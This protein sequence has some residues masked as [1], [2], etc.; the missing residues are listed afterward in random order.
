MTR[1]SQSALPDGR[2]SALSADPHASRSHRR[3]WRLTHAN[4]QKRVFRQDVMYRSDAAKLGVRPGDD[5]AIAV[6]ACEPLRRSVA[7]AAL[8]ALMLSQLL[9]DG[10][11]LLLVEIRAAP[12]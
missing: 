10:Q 4:R 12:Q 8:A 2:I 7:G 3:A 11:E 1:S 5:A 6:L 9:Q